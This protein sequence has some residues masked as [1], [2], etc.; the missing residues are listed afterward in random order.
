[1]QPQIRSRHGWLVVMLI[2]VLL[3]SP[4]AL[5]IPAPRAAAQSPGL[6]QYVRAGDGSFSLRLPAGWV[7]QDNSNDPAIPLFGTQLW[8]GNTAAARDSRLAYNRT[9]TGNISGLGGAV[10]VAN[11][12]AFMQLAGTAPDARGLMD[13][14][15]QLGQNVGGNVSAVS[16]TTVGGYGGFFAVADT[17]AFNNEITLY[18]TLNTP[19]GVVVILVS[20]DAANNTDA[21]AVLLDSIA[22]SLSIP[23][24]PRPTSTPAPPTATPTTTPTT[25]P[26]ATS[27]PPTATPTTI[28]TSTPVSPTPVAA[29]PT[30]NDNTQPGGLGDV[31]T[32]ATRNDDTSDGDVVPGDGVSETAVTQFSSE[33]GQLQVVFPAPWVVDDRINTQNLLVAGENSAAVQTRRTTVETG[34]RATAV[35]G[36]GVVIRLYS[37]ADLDIPG[38]PPRDVAQTLATQAA[39]DFESNGDLLIIPAATISATP[40]VQIARFAGV[41]SI[42][43]EGGVQ[44]VLVFEAEQ[45]VAVVVYTTADGTPL[46]D[47]DTMLAFVENADNL[48]RSVQVAVG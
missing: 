13:I 37:F 5:L 17:L 15:L 8:F 25:T 9:G 42:T 46:Q 6:P 4:G 1:M 38:A 31:F 43:G 27:A 22:R 47:L 28:P 2:A 23:P 36:E 7:T 30:P 40:G 16:P 12:A 39:L 26:T 20:S 11:E 44:A 18:F 32:D 48:L 35:N 24:A 3:W 21:N 29:D 45:V 19:L 33:A 14:L 10:V 34:D 41:Q